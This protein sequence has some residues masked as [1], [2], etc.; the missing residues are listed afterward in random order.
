MRISKYKTQIT[1]SEKR[2]AL[3]FFPSKCSE[4]GGTFRGYFYCF[5]RKCPGGSLIRGGTLIFFSENVLGV[6]LLRGVRLL[7]FPK[8]S[9]GVVY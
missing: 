4:I 8:M 1:S 9:W 6:R 3:I 7:F 2:G 5:F